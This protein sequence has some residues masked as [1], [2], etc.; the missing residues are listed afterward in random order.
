MAFAPAEV[1][2][3]P[4]ILLPD[5]MRCDRAA[6]EAL[7]P[8]VAD[9]GFRTVSLWPLHAREVGI[10]ATLSIL[11]GAGLTV[12]VVEAL[13]QWG[14]GP[15]PEMRAEAEAMVEFASR[16]GAGTVAACLLEPE[17]E[18]FDAMV[19]A[20]TEICALAAARD[21]R[22]CIEFLPWGAVPDLATAWRIVERSGQANGGILLDLWHWQRQ[23]GGP[24]FE[25]LSRIPGERI[26]YV[27]LGDATDSPQP[28]LF[29]EAMSA[30]VLPGDGVVDVGR[31]VAALRG[32]GA[33]PY[34]AAEV[35]NA[36][37]AA[38]G[39]AAMAAAVRD[40]CTAA[41]SS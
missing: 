18:S 31:L 37:L 15:S 8:A 20:F 23:P 34:V 41:L 28:D 6:F 22:V 38:R 14:G 19:D 33:D 13:T 3:C 35:F 16:A 40:A 5:P 9:A 39:P 1:G 11:A 29:A 7:V 12:P 21:Q 27:Q 4:A 24:D 2:L 17:V 32:I 25:L 30:R 10:E 26:H 36:G